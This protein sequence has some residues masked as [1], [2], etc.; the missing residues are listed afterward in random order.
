MVLPEGYAVIDLETTGLDC[1]SD[2]IIEL[3]VMAVSPEMEPLPDSVLINIG[4]PIPPEIV[5]L[6]GITDNVLSEQ[7]LSIN[8]ALRWLKERIGRLPLVGHNIIRFDRGFLLE[9]TRRHRRKAPEQERILDEVDDF[10]ASRF[11]DTAALFKGYKLGARPTAGESHFQYA[12]RVLDMPAPGLRFNL[13]EACRELSID[14]SG[15]LPHRACGDITLT[16]R[17]FERLQELNALQ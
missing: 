16:H 7:G 13:A 9:A 15:V 14:T 11:I 2:L 10:P 8:E 3:G 6:T 4:S 17:L 1:W 12:Q 5:Q